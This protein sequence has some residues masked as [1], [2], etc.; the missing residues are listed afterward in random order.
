MIKIA[1]SLLAANFLRLEEE[2]KNIQEAGADILHLD[3]MDGHF[4]PNIT[5]GPDLVRAIRKITQ[6]PMEAHLMITNPDDY[7]EPFYEAGVDIITVHPEVTFHLNR[8]IQRIKSLG[9][10]AGVALNP[11]TP[12]NVL[13]YVLH[14]LDLVLIMTVDPGFG[15]QAFLK[16][17]LPKIKRLKEI[18]NSRGFELDIAV[19]GGIDLT[20]VPLVSLAGA[21]FFVSG[22]GIFRTKDYAQTI[23]EMRK[24]AHDVLDD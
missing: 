16:A 21:N 3:I 5:F 15:G 20:T 19:D 23:Q 4:V 7:L 13:E 9:A 10:K 11:A 22:T 2:I 18:V 8:T 12:L 6:L 1:P 17:M 14:E 24:K